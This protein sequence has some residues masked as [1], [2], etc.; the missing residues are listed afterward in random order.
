MFEVYESSKYIHL[1]L[2][3]LEGGELFER[4]KAK[5]LYKESDAVKVMR[6]FLDAL[7]YLAEKNIVHRDLKP[8]NLILANKGDD[9]DLRIADFGLAQILSEDE[10]ILYLRCGSPGYVAPELLD[11]RGYDTQADVFSAGVIMYVMLTGR[12]LFRGNN[13]TEILEKN[14]NCILEF[15]QQYWDKISEDAKNLVQGLLKADPNERLTAA[16]ALQHDWFTKG[17]ES[18]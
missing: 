15:P 8:E 3:Y 7:K 13:V 10:K 17:A 4:I 9:H 5:G 16:Q 2:P 18:D 1:L 14:K 11:D 6:N 12:P